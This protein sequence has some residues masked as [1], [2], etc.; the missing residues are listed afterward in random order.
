M[1]VKTPLHY[2]LAALR[3]Y[4][5]GPI[6]LNQWLK[7]RGDLESFFS[8][9]AGLLKTNGFKEEVICNRD[10]LNWSHVE[11]DLIWC[12]QN[13]CSI[14][15]INDA[16]YPPL[17]KEIADPPLVL[18]VQG[19]VSSLLKPQLAIVGSR[20]PTPTGREAAFEFAYSLS[21][22]G[23]VI[24]SGLALGIDAASHWGVLKA[25]GETI[26]VFGTGLKQ[27]Y[28][29]SHAELANN[30][31]EKGALVSEFLPNSK[32]EA[33]HFPRRN[34]IIS[35]LSLGVLVVEAALKSGSLITARLAADQGREV[36]A[37]PGS[38]H[39]PLTR[40]CHKLIH[41]GAKLVEK[42]EDILVELRASAAFLPACVIIQPENHS[43]LDPKLKKL[44]VEI[45]YDITPTDVISLRSGLT[46]SELSSMLLSLE[47]LGY[48]SHVQGGYVRLAKK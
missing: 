6:Q 4:G 26:A 42:A 21:E 3:L 25:L 29:A 30:I 28:P 12:Q 39:N 1:L 47:L 14:I 24:T 35:G 46:A 11:R 34:R 22:A 44:L 32:P 18:F 41:E 2:W 19:Q 37:I 15:T 17:L 16:A 9:S 36:F 43:Q 10:K 8:A 5:A 27:V 7:T 40:G 13:D 48:I 23:L 45:S 38:I 33:Y 31:K 20:N